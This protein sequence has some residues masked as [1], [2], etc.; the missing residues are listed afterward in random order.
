MKFKF[1][2]QLN[3]IQIE[4]ET[5][6][7]YGPCPVYHLS[8]S[9]TGEVVFEGRNFVASEG[10][11]TGQISP[12]KVK[13]LIAAAFEIGFFEM[14]SNYSCEQ[15]FEILPDGTLDR[16]EMSVTDLQLK[17]FAIT[18]G[19]KKKNIRAYVGYPKRL[20]WFHQLVLELGGAEE[21]IG[22]E[23]RY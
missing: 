5:G 7:C 2:V 10:L 21:W 14:A 12:E 16:S 17:T 1:P 8:I 9:G 6:P 20:G 4:L 23:N 11:Q 22:D 15:T 13:E 19:L 3:E 18:L